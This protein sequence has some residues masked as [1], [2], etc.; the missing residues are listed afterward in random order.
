M[1]PW[2]INALIKQIILINKS[3]TNEKQKNIYVNIPTHIIEK[4]KEQ[5]II[6]ILSNIYGLE[7]DKLEVKN[8]KRVPAHL[9]SMFY[10]ESNKKY[11]KYVGSKALFT[12]VTKIQLF[13]NQTSQLKHN[14]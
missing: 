7:C 5:D 11:L 1:M 14:K 3:E 9:L 13:P 2:M 10:K 4:L 12:V 6:D 8:L